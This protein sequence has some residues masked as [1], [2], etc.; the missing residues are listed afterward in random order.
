MKKAYTASKA[1]ITT[2]TT[3]TTTKTTTAT[4]T[5]FCFI[6][7]VIYGLL[8][9]EKIRSRNKNILNLVKVYGLGL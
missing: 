8:G 5:T 7:I 6:S 4:A 3:T 2:T 9:R 1:A